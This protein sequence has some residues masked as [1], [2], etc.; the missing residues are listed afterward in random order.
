MPLTWNNPRLSQRTTPIDGPG[1]TWLRTELLNYLTPSW[2]AARNQQDGD[3]FLHLAAQQWLSRFPTDILTGTPS[4]LVF[5]HAGSLE[6]IEKSIEKEIQ[7]SNEQALN[8]QTKHLLDMFQVNILYGTVQCLECDWQDE[9]HYVLAL[10]D[11][12]FP[13]TDLSY[14]EFPS[15]FN[16]HYALYAYIHSEPCYQCFS[17]RSKGQ[18]DEGVLLW[19]WYQE[20]YN[21]DSD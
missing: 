5:N 2:L 15:T 9:L 3:L 17:H 6:A 11:K 8:R 16:P 10:F 18:I 1:A 19:S 12:K 14:P 4:Y 7:C 13:V 20:E 21:S